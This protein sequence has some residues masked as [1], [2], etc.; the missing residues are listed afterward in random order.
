MAEE[1]VKLANLNETLEDE[2]KVVPELTKKMRE[3]DHKYNA[4]LQMYGEKA[5]EV[6]ELRLDIQEIKEMYRQQ[7]EDLLKKT[8]TVIEGVVLLL[9]MVL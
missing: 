6:T 5:E 1:I 3:I 9:M 8:L 4:V 7:I 2:V